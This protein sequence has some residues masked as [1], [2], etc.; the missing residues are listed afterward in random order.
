MTTA[1]NQGQNVYPAPDNY[2]ASSFPQPVP[3][4]IAE[5]NDAGTL[6]T[7]Q[8]SWTWREVLMAAIDQLLNPAT[9]QGDHDEILAAIDKAIDL[10]HLIQTDVGELP[11]PY[12]DDESDVEAE[13]PDNSQ[14]WYGYVTD[15][16]VPPDELDF[17]ESAALWIA[18]GFVA[19][20]TFE[21]GGLAP[22]ILFHTAVEKFILIQKR[23]DAAET[24]R[25]LIDNQDMKMLDTTPYA[26]GD[27]IEVPLVAPPTGGT[28]E[29]MIVQVS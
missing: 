10:K 18:T 9:W 24:I 2:P 14:E 26:P 11:A 28:H 21:V 8:Y 6:I 17:V 1:G 19:V 13:E 15:A 7:V 16:T 23:G 29:L 12:W 3:A 20:A 5:A 22:A 27:L 25:Y 4:P